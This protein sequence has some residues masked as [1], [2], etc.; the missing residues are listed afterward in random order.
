MNAVSSPLVAAMKSLSFSAAEKC[1]TNQRLAHLTT[2]NTAGHMDGYFLCRG[3][4]WPMNLI[5]G[6]NGTD[7]K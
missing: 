5:F 4:K 6:L 3:L 7:N 2:T 1:F